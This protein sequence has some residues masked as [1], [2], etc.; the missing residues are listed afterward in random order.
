MLD[1]PNHYTFI[2]KDEGAG[3]QSSILYEFFSKLPFN[4][5]QPFLAVTGDAVALAQPEKCYVI[6]LSHGGEISINLTGAKSAMQARWFNPR[7]GEF[8]PPQPVGANAPQ[9]KFIAPD[10]HDWT[11]LIDAR[12]P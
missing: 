10:S 7:S 12:E 5:M 11:L 1:P 9:A 3:K 8:T 4:E 2:L 6:F